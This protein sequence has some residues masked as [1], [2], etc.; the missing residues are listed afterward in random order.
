MKTE[1]SSVVFYIKSLIIH[2]KFP[3]GGNKY[4]PEQSK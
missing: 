1:E 2:I 4:L 3:A